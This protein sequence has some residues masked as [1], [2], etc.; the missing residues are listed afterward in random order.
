M[1][2]RNWS[3]FEEIIYKLQIKYIPCRHKNPKGRVIHPWLTSK[4]KDN[5]SL[6]QAYKVA[7]I[8][9][10]LKFGSIL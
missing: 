5:K 7:K 3:A 9:V 2:D 4:I 6:K 8:V 1:E 10:G